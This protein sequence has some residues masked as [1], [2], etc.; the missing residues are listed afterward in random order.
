[1]VGAIEVIYPAACQDL[2]CTVSTNL[3]P[4]RPT[5]QAPF[6]QRTEKICPLLLAHEIFEK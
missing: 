4:K 2:T 3:R 5:Q 6:G 1:M